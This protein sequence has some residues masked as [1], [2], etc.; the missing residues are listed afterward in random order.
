MPWSSLWYNDFWG[1]RITL[2]ESHKSYRPVTIA[3]FR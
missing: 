1:L 3:V 2:R